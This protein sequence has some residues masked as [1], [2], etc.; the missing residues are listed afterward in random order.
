MVYVA[1]PNE[2][3]FDLDGSF[4]SFSKVAPDGC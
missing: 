1:L 4:H 2:I 3:R